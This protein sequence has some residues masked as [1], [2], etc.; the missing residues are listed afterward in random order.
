MDHSLKFVLLIWCIMNIVISKN[1]IIGTM[2]LEKKLKIVGSN[3][4][5][6]TKKQ[7]TT[8][9]LTGHN[10]PKPKRPQPK[11]PQTGMATNRNGHKPKRPQTGTATTET[12]TDRNGHEPKGPQTETATDQKSH[13]PKRPQTGTTT[14]D[15][16][17]IFC[18]ARV[19]PL[20]YKIRPSVN[21]A[22]LLVV[23][24]GMWKYFA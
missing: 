20:G 8:Q 24:S 2:Y 17:P 9:P 21:N 4:T 15:D 11:R 5:I 19:W 14:Q 7:S 12:A 18:K 23:Y 16:I 13:K 1:A 10:G 6:A 22:W 3:I